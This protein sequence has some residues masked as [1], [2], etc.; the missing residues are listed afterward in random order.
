LPLDLETADHYEI[1][2]RA[3]AAL[4]PEATAYLRIVTVQ[5]R[6]NEEARLIEVLRAREPR[7]IEMG[8]VASHI[9]RRVVGRECEAVTVGVWPDRATIRAAT[10][11]GPERPL[12]ESELADWSDRIRLETYDGIEIAPRLPAVSGPPI[13]VFDDELR[14]VDIT[15]SAAATLGWEAADLIGRSVTEFSRTNP[16]RLAS[17]LKELLRDGAV[18]GEGRWH[19]PERGLVFLRFVARRDVP[20]AGRHT[21][22]VHRW[23]QPKPTASDLDAALES[24]FP[25]AR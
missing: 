15:A 11:G 12:F 1:V 21:A 13:F 25:V 10:G 20:I 19:V 3:F 8:L 9:G 2:G 22:L 5:A 17:N 16:E 24:A 4:P 23:N 18:S 6:Q 7:M 14:I